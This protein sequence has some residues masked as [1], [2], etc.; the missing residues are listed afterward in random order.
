MKALARAFRYQLLLEDGRYASV[1]EM[2]AAER[3]ERPI[4]EK[5]NAANPVHTDPRRP[6]VDWHQPDELGLPQLLAGFAG[7]G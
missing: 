6:I 1:S 4:A 3:L 7:L 2:A 5:P